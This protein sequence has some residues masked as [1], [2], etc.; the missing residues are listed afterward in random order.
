MLPKRD[1]PWPMKSRRNSLERR[2]GATSIRNIVAKPPPRLALPA[3]S[4]TCSGT[5]TDSG[6]SG[7]GPAREPSGAGWEWSTLS[8]LSAGATYRRPSTSTIGRTFLRRSGRDVLS[9]APNGG[10]RARDAP[11][12]AQG[13]KP[14][15][16]IASPTLSSATATAPRR[17]VTFRSRDRRQTASKAVDMTRRRRSATRSPSHA[18]P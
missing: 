3:A 6:G 18:K 17:G 16:S 9:V 1:T 10:A 12:E 11:P 15:T 2:S 5:A 8:S 7:S 14:L 13:N 4:A